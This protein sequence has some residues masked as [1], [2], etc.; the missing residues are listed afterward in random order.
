[1]SNDVD[2]DIYEGEGDETSVAR[3]ASDG[4]HRAI[5]DTDRAEQLDISDKTKTS[6]A[7]RTFE[8]PTN[9]AR[10][11]HS[12]THI[13]RGTSS[14]EFAAQASCGAQDSGYYANVPGRLHV[15]TYCG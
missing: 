9:T 13:L 15:H 2:E 7:M 5:A 3:E 6:R 11:L 12:M 4:D 10:M 14:N 1:M 8:P